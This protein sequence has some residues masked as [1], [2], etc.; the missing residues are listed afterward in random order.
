MISFRVESE[1]DEYGSFMLASQMKIQSV[2]AKLTKKIIVKMRSFHLVSFLELT[3]Y[4][5]GSNACWFS[6]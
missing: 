6:Q 4:V 3:E 2:T 1:D 5:C